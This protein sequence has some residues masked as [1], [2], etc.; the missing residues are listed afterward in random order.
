MGA[1]AILG[2]ALK[3]LGDIAGTLKGHDKEKIDIAMRRLELA[4]DE[5]SAVTAERDALKHRV[6][7]LEE[8][9]KELQEKLSFRELE[10]EFTAGRNG[11]LYRK[12]DD[13]TQ[14][15]PFC[16]KDKARMVRSTSRTYVCPVCRVQGVH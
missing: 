15:G 5:T 10:D 1:I 12:K 7:E 8:E 3:V 14:E 9:V 11:L 6:K 2:D 13:G 4:K 16:P